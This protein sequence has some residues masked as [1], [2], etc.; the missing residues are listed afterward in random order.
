MSNSK[1]VFVVED[2]MVISLVINK[3]LKGL[4]YTIVGKST[5][6]VDAIDKILSLKPDIVLMDI[7]INGELDGVET[8]AKI[9]E[10]LDIDVIFL[11]GNSDKLNYDRAQKVG[12][13]D[14]IHKPFT[15]S[16]LENALDLVD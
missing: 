3:M 15:V 11:T 1:T 9:K 8:V 13:V 10:T 2:D 5:S 16:D 14:L 4:G 12:F 6:G 7:R